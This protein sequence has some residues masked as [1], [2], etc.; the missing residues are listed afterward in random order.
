MAFEGTGRGEFA[1][2]M[3]DHIFGD[4]YRYVFS[5]VMHC[6]GVTYKARQDGR[7][8]GPGLTTF[9]SLASFM[10]LI[11]FSRENATKGPFFTDL[12]TLTPPYLTC[13]S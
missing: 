10:A 1:E 11:F 8:T 12:D 13:V 5:S 7:S 2:F 4:I 6:D 3:T 9:F